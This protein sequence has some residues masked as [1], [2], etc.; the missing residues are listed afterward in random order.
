MF[1]ESIASNQQELF[2]GVTQ[3]LGDK[4]LEK[5]SDSKSWYN[6]FYEEVTSKVKEEI[7]EPLYSVESGRP[8]ASIR[9]LIGMIILKDGH[10]WT[11]E[12]L[13]E[14]CHFNM[15][16]MRALGLTNIDDEV[17]SES[18]YY[19]FKVKLVR[20]HDDT[21]ENLFE[22]LFQ[23]ITSGQVK[24]YKVNGKSIRMD[25]KLI[26]SNIRTGCQL[27][28]VLE[29]V[30]VFFRSLEKGY[31]KKLKKKRDREFVEEIMSKPVTNHLYGMTKDEKSNW[32][33]KLGF[34]IRKLLN[35]YVDHDNKY[36]E[37]LTQMYKEHYIETEDQDNPPRP[38]EKEEMQA[39]GIQSVHD[40]DAAY[41]CKGRGNARQQVSGYSANI[42]ETTEGDLRLITDVQLEKATQSDSSYLESAAKKTAIVTQQPIE[43]VHTDGGY[44]S[45]ENRSRFEDH[46]GSQWH[47]AKCTG[48]KKQYQFK[49]EEDGT[50]MI[51][52]PSADTWYEAVK[53]RGGRYRIPTPQKRTKYRYFSKAQVEAG[54][55]LTKVRPKEINKGIR[56]NVE[57]TIHQ[58]FH[59][60][61]GRK[62]KYRGL[63][64]HKIFVTS[65]SLWVNCRRIT[66]RITQ[67][68]LLDTFFGPFVHVNHRY[69]SHGLVNSILT[70]L[71]NYFPCSSLWPI[72]AQIPLCTYF[73]ESTH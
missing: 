52:D 36:Y 68:S 18:T 24:K 64:R 50:I 16:V 23:Q 37:R 49:Q 28:K 61:N 73:S 33:R 15:A 54:I 41:R 59:T 8:N 39:D 58:V 7:F 32:L 21:G 40:P 70:F 31:E 14:N 25:S 12:K 1:K 46:I 26:Q 17:P 62:S 47:L 43:Q 65:R 45:I 67:K 6:V 72:S 38:K 22:T 20:H 66:A 53:S 9:R 48:G 44:D 19:D 3:H 10:N 42:T 13:Y 51:Y 60:L 5:L 29:A 2:A 30:Q 11:D 63:L 34:L 56:A 69:L 57:S 55:A 71:A 4:K 27:H 35:I